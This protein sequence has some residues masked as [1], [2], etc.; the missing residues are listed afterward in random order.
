MTASLRP[1]GR[2][3]RCSLRV[4]RAGGTALLALPRFWLLDRGRYRFFVLA[5]DLA[6]NSQ[7]KVASNTLRVR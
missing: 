3:Q 4:A 2:T 1:H 7:A 5:R 6:G